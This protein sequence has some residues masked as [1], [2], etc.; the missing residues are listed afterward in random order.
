MLL[1]EGSAKN[2]NETQPTSK[3]WQKEEKEPKKVLKKVPRKML[4]TA[5]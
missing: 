3:K 5:K 2:P 4:A 1:P